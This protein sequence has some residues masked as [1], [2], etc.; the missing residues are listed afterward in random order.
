[1]QIKVVAFSLLS[2]AITAYASAHA[3]VDDFDAIPWQVPV[4][5]ASCNWAGEYNW[6]VG[7]S[8]HQS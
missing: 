5:A 2:L 6:T 8:D 1:M 4:A 3:E 7:G